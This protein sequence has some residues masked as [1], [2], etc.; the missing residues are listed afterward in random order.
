LFVLELCAGW[1]APA[2]LDEADVFLEARATSDLVSN[3]LVC[4]MLRLLNRVPA[5]HPLPQTTRVRYFDLAFESHVTVALRYEP[6]APTDPVQI[7]CNLLLRVVTPLNE[8]IAPD[9][10]AAH[11]P[12]GAAGPGAGA[13]T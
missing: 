5:G 11:A 7:W 10:L 9:A 4:V 1:D 8:G 12:S 3:A 6:L 2:L 13:G